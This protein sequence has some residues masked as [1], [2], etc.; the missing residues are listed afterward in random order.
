MIYYSAADIAGILNRAAPRLSGKFIFTL[1]PR[2]PA[3]MAMF[4][5]GKLFPRKD[6]SPTMIPHSLPLVRRAM[7]EAHVPGT[8]TEVERITAG[9]YISTA[10]CFA[11]GRT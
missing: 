1:A 9:F 7:Q 3:L 11:G 5:L 2:T 4:R 6:R 10:L 8:L